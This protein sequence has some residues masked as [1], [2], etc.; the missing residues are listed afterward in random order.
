MSSSSSLNISGAIQ[1]VAEIFQRHR[2]PLLCAAGVG[3]TAVA[4]WMWWRRKCGEHVELR[5][6]GT[7]SQL[8]IHPIKSCQAISVQEAECLE[9]GLRHEELWDRHWLVVTEEGQMVTGRQEPRIVLI[10]VTGC[11]DSLCLEAPGMEKIM[12]PVVQP[13][14]NKILDCRVFSCDIQ[15]RDCGDE[16][17]RWLTSY[18]QS[19]GPYRLVHF[20]PDMMKPRKSKNAERPFR[21]KDIVAYPDASPI[22]LLSETSL[23]ELNRRLEEPVSLANFRP[24]IVVSGCEAFSEDGWDDVKVGTA[25]LKRVMACGRCILTTVNPKTGV[26]TRQEPLDTLRTFR[27]SDESLSHLYK[28]APLFG[29][30]YGVD[31]IGK[32]RVGDPVYQVVRQG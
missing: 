23:E 4:S 19:S 8:L 2:L 16:V 30:Y 7:V 9:L 10:S 13:K 5:K 24:C 12:V 18:F 17:S 1:S 28:K 32:L 31:K 25:R 29:Q 21:E 11:G 27:L 14:S 3:V 15:G 6:V 20:E 22:M 26:L